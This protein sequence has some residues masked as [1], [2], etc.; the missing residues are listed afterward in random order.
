M[1][2]KF[3]LQTVLDVRHSKVESLEI[4]LGRLNQEKVEKENYMHALMN[5]QDELYSTLHV[6]MTGD[7]DLFIINHMRAN[8]NQ[9]S[10]QIT[11]T[12]QSIL[13]LEQRIHAKR[14][15]LI[16]AKKE[17]ESLNVLKNKEVERFHEEEKEKEKR[18]MDD[19]YISQ[20]FRQRRS[21]ASS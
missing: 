8:I 5:S 12:S 14:L 7:M 17:E 10:N 1:V 11:A 19:V 9:I 21:E 3:S 2:P 13:E 20:G 4:D 16:E 6:H 18:Y 15:A